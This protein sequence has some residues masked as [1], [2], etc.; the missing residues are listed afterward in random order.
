MFICG[1][2]AWASQIPIELVVLAGLSG[3]LRKSA[4]IRLH[5]GLRSQYVAV[6]QSLAKRLGVIRNMHSNQKRL[7][8]FM[9]KVCAIRPIKTSM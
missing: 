3:H 4:D 5:T 2:A 9:L 1:R 7:V 8:I 6:S